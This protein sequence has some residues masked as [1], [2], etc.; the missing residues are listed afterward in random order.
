MT[1]SDGNKNCHLGFSSSPAGW[2]V[3]GLE[4]TSQ[5]IASL[6]HFY[7][8]GGENDTRKYNKYSTEELRLRQCRC[9][10]FSALLI[11]LPSAVVTFRAWCCGVV[12]L[13]LLWCCTAP[14]SPLS[15][16]HLKLWG[17]LHPVLYLPYTIYYISLTYI[18][19]INICASHNLCSEHE[20]LF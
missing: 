13:W 14:P 7:C 12:W 11:S 2:V 17:H 1:N 9:S 15:Q 19:N 4:D 3:G 16:C 8:C 5:T 20:V 6:K 18:N 10:V